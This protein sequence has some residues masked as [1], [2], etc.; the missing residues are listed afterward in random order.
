MPLLQISNVVNLVS[1]I[2]PLETRLKKR[3]TNI[4]ICDVRKLIFT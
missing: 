2:F 1:E 3:K 4:E